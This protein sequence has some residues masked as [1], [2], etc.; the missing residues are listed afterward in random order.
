[1][2]IPQTQKA[3]QLIG[4]DKL[5]F[6]PEKPVYKPNQWQILCKVEVV[7]LCFSD[8][9]LLKQFDS[10]VRKG[11]IIDGVDQAV[12]AEYP[13]YKV[14]L[15]PT[16]PG[17]EIVVRVI[18]Q[19]E[20]V[21]KTKPG[22]RYLVQADHRW[23][24]TKN[25]N[26]AIGYNIE[27]GLQ[28]YMLFDERVSLSPDGEFMLIEVSDECSAS[29]VALVEP[30]ACV[31]D[32][33]VVKER[34]TLTKGGKM[35]VVA[36]AGF[37]K[38]AFDAFVEKYGEPGSITAVGTDEIAGAE[39]AADVESL[40][41]FAY[42]DLVYFGS[43]ADTL[44]KL[45]DK[46]ANRGLIIIAL[47]GGR[48]DKEPQTAVG[49]VH[50]G[51]IRITGT[52]GS[53][54]AEAMK[55]IPATGEIRRGDV[56]NVIGAGGPMGVMHVV[57]NI[58][59]GVEGVTVYAGDLDDDRLAAMSRFAEPMAKERGV[60]YKS[61]NPKKDEGPKNVDY[62]ALMAPVPA[63]AAACV[64]NGGKNSIVNIF[65]GIPA[66][67]TGPIDMNRYI[68]NQMYFI[69]TS[70]STLHD[71]LVVLDKVLTGKLDTNISVAAVSGLK[72]AVE[73]IR[74]VENHSIPGKILVY[75]DCEDLGLT[76]LDKLEAVNPQAT[77][78]LDNGVWTKAAENKLLNK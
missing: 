73:G 15:E 62:S 65:A 64:K 36:E 38:A 25:S 26:G 21:T 51:G 60:G 71:M 8:L 35:L 69:G 33:Y 59:Q 58:C 75:P 68:D 29:A 32:A 11:K 34:Q 24:R 40:T 18:E 70:G 20:K 63:L 9:K 7:G 47:C 23:L 48:F 74:A 66:N 56:I 6:N 45:F 53:D 77:A 16:V 67:V 2:T 14:D 22:G 54:P 42:D 30:W 13:A 19:G 46:T 43:N 27:G 72:A 39:K 76:T 44:E 41:D 31:E 5:K 49:R 57:R 28:Q 10:H 55:A 12:L 50:Y 3:V 1:M 52:T 4:P 17:H 61:Y 37:D 78:A